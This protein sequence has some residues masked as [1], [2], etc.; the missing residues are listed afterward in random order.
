MKSNG[1]PPPGVLVTFLGSWA[2]PLR[3]IGGPQLAGT[4]DRSVHSVARMVRFDPLEGV[5]A[6][7]ISRFPSGLAAMV[8]QN[9]K[10]G[11]KGGATVGPS[12]V[13]DRLPLSSTLIVLTTRLPVLPGP[14]LEYEANSCLPPKS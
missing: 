14:L 11:A 9:W 1:Y 10:P 13:T 5:S 4:L 7:T 6:Q 8:D 3:L 2:A 12:G